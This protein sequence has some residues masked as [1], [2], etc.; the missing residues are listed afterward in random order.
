MRLVLVLAVLAFACASPPSEPDFSQC[1]L[2]GVGDE[3]GN[4]VIDLP[5]VVAC[6][7]R[8]SS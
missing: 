1:E 4:G 7:E 6:V 8:L 3:R 2:E 5:D